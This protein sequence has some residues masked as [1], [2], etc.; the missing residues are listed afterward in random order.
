MSPAADDLQFERAEPVDPAVTARC[1]A[2]RRPLTS[3]VYYTLGPHAVCSACRDRIS[4]SWSQGS[5]FVR[6][7]RAL[8][9]GLGAAAVGAGLYFGISMLTGIEFG[10]IAVVVGF[11]V[12][13]AVRWGSGGRG[14]WGYQILAAVLTYL[15]IVTTY[16]PPIARQFPSSP[17]QLQSA[18]SQPNASTPSAG[19]P[20]A[21][22]STPAVATH[23]VDPLARA[24]WHIV[25][26]LIIYAVASAAPFLLGVKN[27]IGWI[28]IGFA[29]YQAWRLNRRVRAEFA[30]PFE[31]RAKPAAGLPP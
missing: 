30:G 26:W 29:L 17:E 6:G 22:D 19:S 7:L 27:L 4:G 5:G 31:L 12:G 25:R 15:A 3:G 8:A 24:R 10:L 14:G 13:R 18:T 20:Q 11:L 2:C 23:L 16:V 1:A 28:I 21:A 9:A